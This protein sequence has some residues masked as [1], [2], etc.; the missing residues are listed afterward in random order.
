VENAIFSEDEVRFTK[1]FL[2]TDTVIYQSSTG[3]IDTIMFYQAMNDNVKG[4]AEKTLRPIPLVN[5][6]R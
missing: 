6:K 5:K 4:R 2:K 3:L 1:P